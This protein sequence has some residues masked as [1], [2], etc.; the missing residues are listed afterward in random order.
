MAHLHNSSSDK[1]RTIAHGGRSRRA[2]A[3]RSEHALDE[4]NRKHSMDAYYRPKLRGL[5]N[6]CLQ[7]AEEMD[8]PAGA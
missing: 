6:A 2:H 8:L 5:V 7:D 4:L 1:K 3:G